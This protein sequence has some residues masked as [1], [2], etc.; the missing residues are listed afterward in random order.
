MSNEDF[1]RNQGSK[2]SSSDELED[3]DETR[4]RFENCSTHHDKGPLRCLS[5][6][7]TTMC[8]IVAF[9]SAS[10]SMA[11][12]KNSSAKASKSLAWS[13]VRNSTVERWALR[14]PTGWI[15]GTQEKEDWSKSAKRRTWWNE[16]DIV[17]EQL[18]SNEI[19]DIFSGEL[20]NTSALSLC[21][22]NPASFEWPRW[23]GEGTRSEEQ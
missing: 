20:E 5:A 2:A 11:G 4:A 21:Q 15:E 18:F 16:S 14:W 19:T 13:G 8:F 23:M 7:V 10:S 9:S 3:D 22:T 1:W 17:L 6:L 12:F